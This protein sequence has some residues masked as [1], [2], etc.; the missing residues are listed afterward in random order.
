M[1]HSWGSA[2]RSTPGYTRAPAPQ[3]E[4]VTAHFGEKFE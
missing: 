3:A 2:P 4:N 1:R